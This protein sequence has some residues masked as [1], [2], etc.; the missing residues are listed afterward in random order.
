MCMM[1]MYFARACKGPALGGKYSAD[2]EDLGMSDVLTRKQ[3]MEQ[4]QRR[5]AVLDKLMAG[6][7]P[8]AAFEEARKKLLLTERRLERMDAAAVLAGDCPLGGNEDNGEDLDGG[9]RYDEL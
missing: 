6:G 4:L 9:G 1:I 5:R 8:R 2:K 3:L 7:A